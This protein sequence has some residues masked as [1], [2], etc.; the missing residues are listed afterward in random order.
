MS[1]DKKPRHFSASP[2]GQVKAQYQPQLQAQTQP[3]AQALF[4]APA[5]LSSPKKSGT[6]LWK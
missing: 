5:Q 3:Q 4:N 2:K 6:S 1:D